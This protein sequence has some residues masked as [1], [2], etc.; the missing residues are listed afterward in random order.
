VRY[1]GHR[2]EA[3][4]PAKDQRWVVD[5]IMASEVPDAIEFLKRGMDGV[6]STQARPARRS[7]VAAAG[8]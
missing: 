2:I 8:D 3:I 4:M 7:R 6:L 5:Q 1:L